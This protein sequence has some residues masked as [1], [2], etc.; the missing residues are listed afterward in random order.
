[1]I[2]IGALTRKEVFGALEEALPSNE[3]S[4]SWWGEGLAPVPGD[5]SVVD[6]VIVE[7]LEEVVRGRDFDSSSLAGLPVAGLVVSETSF[8]LAEQL[9]IVSLLSDQSDLEAWI[10]GVASRSHHRTPGLPPRGS[11]IA[12]WG[13][14]GAPGRTSIA[15]TVAGLLAE[16]GAPV[17]LID[18]D[19]SAASVSVALNLQ[20][21]GSGLLAA[22]RMARVDTVEAGPLRSVMTEYVGRRTRFQVLTGLLAPE[23]FADIDLLALSRVLEVLKAGGSLVV[24]D[25]AGALDHFPHEVIGG[26][27][28]NGVQRAVIDNADHIIA[29]SISTPIHTARFLRSWPLL[30]ALAGSTPIHVVFNKVLKSQAPAVSEATYALWTHAGIENISTIPRD[31]VSLARAEID[32]VTAVDLPQKSAAVD[33]LRTVVG[34]LGVASLPRTSLR[35]DP[36]A[37]RIRGLW[38]EKKPAGKGLP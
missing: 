38:R 28:R 26:P 27:I 15:I 12:V 4:V 34:A 35:Q 17:V 36:K 37:S 25:L 2:R 14:V 19:T 23:R 29:L 16:S 13:P 10:E 6:G 33:A 20:H 1:M 21:P 32:G 9:G 30:S 7:L 3:V 5:P 11:V 24:V 18:A 8:A 31:S 22:T